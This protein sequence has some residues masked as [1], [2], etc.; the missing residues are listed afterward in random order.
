M[1]P[2][3]DFLTSLREFYSP[4]EHG[5]RAEAKEVDVGLAD[6]DGAWTDADT[7]T[8]RRG[9]LDNLDAVLG[10]TYGAHAT[11]SRRRRPLRRRRRSRL[12]RP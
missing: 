12:R 6:A 4:D 5:P 2:S 9:Y 11:L 8:L 1:L 7:L 3:R 10:M